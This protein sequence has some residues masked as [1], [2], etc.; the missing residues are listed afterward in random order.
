[1]TADCFRHIKKREHTCGAVQLATEEQAAEFA[2]LQRAVALVSRKE[3]VF[4]SIRRPH[5][6]AVLK[7][8]QRLKHGELQTLRQT[9]RKALQ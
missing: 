3:V 9:S 5:H 2:G 4:H 6:A 8:R 7:A 1:M